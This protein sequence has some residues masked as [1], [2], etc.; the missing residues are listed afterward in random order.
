M[1][2]KSDKNTLLFNGCKNIDDLTVSLR[3]TEHLVATNGFSL[4]LN[5]F[6]PSGSSTD[7]LQYLFQGA[8][9]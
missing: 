3:V 9:N 5:T 2:L 1:A 4:Q 7:W 6:N 8:G